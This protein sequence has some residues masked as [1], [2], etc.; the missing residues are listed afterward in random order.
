L[1]RG[2]SPEAVFQERFRHFFKGE[3]KPPFNHQA[4]AAAGFPRDYYEPLTAVPTRA[5]AQGRTTLPAAP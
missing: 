4:R 2:L 3:L 5:G 1:A